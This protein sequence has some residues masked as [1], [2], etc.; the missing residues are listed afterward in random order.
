MI[1][2]AESVRVDGRVLNVVKMRCNQ[3]TRCVDFSC[4]VT[5]LQKHNSAVITIKSRL[6][7]ATFVEVSDILL[8]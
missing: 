5:N 1:V 7:N 2:P 8:K 3:N 4:T 6:W